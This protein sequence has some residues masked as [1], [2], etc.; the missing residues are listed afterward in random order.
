LSSPSLMRHVCH[1]GASGH[2]ALLSFLLRFLD[3]LHF[4]SS[5]V[6][7]YDALPFF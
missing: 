1:Q 3:I 2:H 6:S 4:L 5:E 7:R